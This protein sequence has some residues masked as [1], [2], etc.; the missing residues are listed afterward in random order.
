M[1]G[2]KKE[3]PKEFPKE[4]LTSKQKWDNF[5]FY[6]TGKVVAV[7]IAAVL[8]GL[9]IF[10]L[11]TKEKYDTTIVYATSDYVLDDQAT[12]I[13]G[14]LEQY[15]SDA[16]GD[17]KVSILLDTVVLNETTTQTD[18]T[19][20]QAQSTKLMAA[21]AL[22]EDSIFILDQGIY[23]SL[24]DSI[25]GAFVNL[26]EQYPN[27]DFVQGDKIMLDEFFASYGNYS[28]ILSGMFICQRPA[29]N[30]H[31]YEKSEQV[32]AKYAAESELVRKV[33]EA[34]QTAEADSRQVAADS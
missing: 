26:E 9:Y 18:P 30:M 22:N 11:V 25:D 17:G 2:R 20:A 31:N 4:P 7:L 21:F 28:S 24:G 1:A 27:C 6:N 15:M 12:E 8:V 29:D 5:W 14:M 19:L 13:D 34:I 10:E 23:D 3:L 33:V 32:Q 16:N